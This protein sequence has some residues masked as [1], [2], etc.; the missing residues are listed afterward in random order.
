MLGQVA[1][2]GLA[3]KGGE[4]V[5]KIGDVASKARKAAIQVPYQQYADLAPYYGGR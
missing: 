3:G 5:G 1:V 4:A 2:G